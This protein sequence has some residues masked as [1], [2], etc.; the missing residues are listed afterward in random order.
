MRLEGLKIGKS[1]KKRERITGVSFSKHTDTQFFGPYLQHPF[2][3]R[4]PSL[5]GLG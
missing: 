3:E 2:S 4:S 5:P 1:L